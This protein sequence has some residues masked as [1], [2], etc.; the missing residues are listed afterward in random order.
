MRR[1]LY[2]FLIYMII[3]LFSGFYYRE[4]TKAH[5]FT[6]D[7]QLSLVHTHTLILGMFMFLLL[8]PLEKV[9]KLSSYYLFNWF[10]VIYHI[11]ILVTIGMMTVKGT[12]QV[13]G[14]TVP[15]SFSGFAGMG[16]TAMLA[17]LLIL[18]FLLRQAI[19]KEP[20]D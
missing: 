3:G 5:H 7:T 15:A 10:F 1:L 18:F 17:A 13:I 2:S 14:K 8:L 9:F 6:G 19:I 11:G 16:H 12:Y 4:L 20:R